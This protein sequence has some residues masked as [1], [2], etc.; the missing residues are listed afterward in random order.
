MT[1]EDEHLFHALSGTLPKETPLRIRLTSDPRS[2][3]LERF[4]AR[5]SALVPE[6]RIIREHDAGADPPAIV[7]PSGLRF[8]AIPTGTEA[9][10]FGEALTGRTPALPPGILERVAAMSLPAAMNVYVMAQCA[11]CPNALRQLASLAAANN[12]IRLSVIDGALFP[13]LADRDH[14]R[15][16][17]TVVLDGRFRWSGAISMHEI[18]TLLTTRDPVDLGPVSVEMMLKEGAAQ[19]VAE[20][21]FERNAVFPALLELV[22]HAQW[23]LRAGAMV[24]VEALAAMSPALGREALERLWRRFDAES[25][26]VRGDIL[27]LSGEAGGAW[28]LPAI[29]SVMQRAVAADIMEAAS[30]ALEKIAS[31]THPLVSD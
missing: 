24:A 1:P 27:F 22:C 2:G 26:S 10:P 23:P 14:I 9:A 6:L 28:L 4:C 7:L 20:M 13:E 12:R 15:A 11:Y 30:E 25:D 21:M 31:R 16:V 17:P 19:R 5:L 29:R 3:E 18:A 8:L